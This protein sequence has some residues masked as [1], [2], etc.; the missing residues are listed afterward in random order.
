M[1]TLGTEICGVYYLSTINTVI[2]IVAKQ[3]AIF[4]LIRVAE[5]YG[6]SL[7]KTSK[8]AGKNNDT[9]MKVVSYREIADQ[10]KVRDD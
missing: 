4:F 8:L 9:E 2:D 7:G 1:T 5:F 6:K 10:V 3:V